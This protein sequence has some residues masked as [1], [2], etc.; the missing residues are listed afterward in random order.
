MPEHRVLEGDPVGAEDGACGA[1]DLQGA[2]HVVVLAKAD[3]LRAEPSLVLASSQVECEERASLHRHHHLHQLSLG[4]LER[5]DRAVEL[6]ALD[7]VVERRLV[8]G[9]C[10]P[11]RPEGDPEAGLVETGEG[12]TH[13]RDPGEHELV[14]DPDV[15]QDQLGGHRR[16]Q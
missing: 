7:R 13:R 15:V 9:P 11:H 14:G 10:R 2:S 16:P 5:G 12:A 6:P 1:G 3:L 8:T 4:E